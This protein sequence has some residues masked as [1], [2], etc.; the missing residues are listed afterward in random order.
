MRGRPA[1][2]A[3]SA[4]ER[5]VV[6]TLFCDLVS[7]TAHSEAADHEL[8]DELLRRYNALARR[9]VEAHGGVVEKFIGDAV[10]A[11]FGFPHVHDDD[12]ERAVRVGLQL[13]AEA[14]S[15]ELA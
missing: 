13:A 10:L 5:K 4:E 3:S 14:G 7:Y 12:A 8:I 1:R 2:Q 6:T 15:L 9:L 11:V